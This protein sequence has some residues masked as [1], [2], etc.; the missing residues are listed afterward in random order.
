MPLNQ[1]PAPIQTR[2]IEGRV[3]HFEIEGGRGPCHFWGS[4]TSY[5]GSA[6]YCNQPQTAQCA[7][8][9][10][11]MKK[12][13]RLHLF[14]FLFDLSSNPEITECCIYLKH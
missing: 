7:P 1:Y 13:N 8:V 2:V 10:D 9:M 12:V 14:L 4:K 5:K 11:E 6:N 3:Q